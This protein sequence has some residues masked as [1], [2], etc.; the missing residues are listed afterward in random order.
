MG[1]VAKGAETRAGHELGDESF[2]SA[3][4]LRAYMAEMEMAEAL[5]EVD[6]MDR[7]ETARKE[8][9]KT[10]STPADLAEIKDVVASVQHK[11]RSAAL[12]GATEIMVLRFP[13]A[14]CTDKGRAINNAEKD[15]P[16]TLTGRPREAYEFWR[17]HLRPAGYRLKAMI[18][19]WP[20]GLPGDVG[21]FLQ[22][23][24]AKH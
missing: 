14:L 19:E 12:R 8:L 7:A 22:W 16:D 1:A 11:V 6:A 9:I 10:L 5:K 18:I 2:M 15:W 21:F 3:A 4:D 17:D 24:D 23:G 13:C 20:G